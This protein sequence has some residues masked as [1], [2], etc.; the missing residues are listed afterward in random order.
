M[1][2][3]KCVSIKYMLPVLSRKEKND[4]ISHR[5]T[6]HFTSAYDVLTKHISLAT[7]RR[8]PGLFDTNSQKFSNAKLKTCTCITYNICTRSKGA[9][10]CMLDVE[11]FFNLLNIDTIVSKRT[12]VY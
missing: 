3:K 11:K 4:G 9:K 12:L 10:V 5:D 8:K 1:A 7:R 2:T 6:K